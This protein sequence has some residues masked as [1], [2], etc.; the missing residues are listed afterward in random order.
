MEHL[1]QFRSKFW[2]L[3]IF[4]LPACQQT[5]RQRDPFFM[6]NGADPGFTV[7]SDTTLYKSHPFTGIVFTCYPNGK[8]TA[9]LAGFLAGKENGY[10][11][12]YYPN[13]QLREIREFDKGFKTGTYTAWWD[14]GQKRL[15]YFFKDD[16]YQGSCRE[17]N[18]QGTLTKEM[19][20][21]NGYEAGP[22]KM[23]YDNGRVRANYIILNGRRYGLLGTKNCINVSDSVF[24]K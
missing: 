19:N 20:Y 11:K 9:E 17:W 23:F 8:D 16:E 6:R 24:K 22:Q 14:N 7:H 3:V 12:R 18:T 2:G 15:Q 13:G 21:Q 1:G 4:L 10:R 5:T